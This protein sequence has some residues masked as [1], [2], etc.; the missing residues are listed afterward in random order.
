MCRMRISVNGVPLL[1]MEVDG[2]CSSRYPFNH[3]I[4]ESGAAT[5]KYEALPLNGEAQLHKEAYLC[6]R[7]EQYDLDSNLEPKSTAASFESHHESIIPYIVHE[8]P[9]Q[10]SVPYNV[11]GWKQSV[12][13]ERYKNQLQRLVRLKYDNLI[14]MMRNRDLTPYEEA[15]REREDMV[16]V[17]FYLSDQEKQDRMKSIK[18]AIMNCTEVVPL[19]TFDRLEFA[20]DSRLVRLVKKE[21]QSALRIRNDKTNELTILDMWLHVKAGS[22]KLSII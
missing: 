15:F 12:K 2:Q 20:A 13:L 19:S 9:F 4:L 16:G 14:S 1:N 22:K 6:C 5:I 11:T 21:G 17:C 10:V 8:V 7:V 18:D 3:L